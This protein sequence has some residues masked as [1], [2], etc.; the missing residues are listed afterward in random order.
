[1]NLFKSIFFY[2]R[3]L[4]ILLPF[5]FVSC[6]TEN[7]SR[8]RFE[9][10]FINI[11]DYYMLDNGIVDIN[12][13]GFLDIY[14]VNHTALSSLLLGNGQGTFRDIYEYWG[15]HHQEEF[16]GLEDSL[17]EPEIKNESGLYIFWKERQIH[18]KFVSSKKSA[19]SVSG[20]I[21]LHSPVKIKSNF[22]CEASIESNL[23]SPG[24]KK[25]HIRFEFD[26]E[27]SKGRLVIQPD[28]AAAPVSFHIESQTPLPYIRIGRYQLNPSSHHFVL[29]LKDR[30][31]TAW[32]DWNRDGLI[33]LAIS[34]GGFRGKTHQFSL[35]NNN[36]IFVNLGKKFNQVS[37]LIQMKKTPRR[38]FLN[39]FPKCLY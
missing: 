9:R 3:F 19:Q 5:I 35:Y 25:T 29:R 15:L 30:H 11:H 39:K 37:D 6:D 16:P 20:Q 31:G 34:N 8:N 10:K 14:T 7:Q 22:N 24:I 38:F 21:T 33:D 26:T 28:M 1:M 36:E 2:S 23:L 17:V 27:Q 18:I 13:D 4:L 12:A 32:S